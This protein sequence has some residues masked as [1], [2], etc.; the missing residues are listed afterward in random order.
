M[1]FTQILHPLTTLLRVGGGWGGDGN[2][3]FC[4]EPYLKEHSSRLLQVKKKENIQ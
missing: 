2:D 1:L 3:K 4:K